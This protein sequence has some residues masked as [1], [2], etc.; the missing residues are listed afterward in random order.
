M[1]AIL[2]FFKKVLFGMA[3]GLFTLFAVFNYETVNFSLFGLKT[4]QL[5]LFFVIFIAFFLGALIGML[6]FICFKK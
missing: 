4:Y 2:N 5:P 3:F 1:K 6:F